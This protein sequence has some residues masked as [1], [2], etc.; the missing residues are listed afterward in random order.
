M[1]QESFREIY[2][3][4]LKQIAQFTNQLE[5]EVLA[6]FIVSIQQQIDPRED[7]AIFERLKGSLV[8]A[9]KKAAVGS[10]TH[11]TEEEFVGVMSSVNQRAP[12]D[13][14]EKFLRK[15]FNR[16]TRG[17]KPAVPVEEYFDFMQRTFQIR[18]TEEEQN[19]IKDKL[20]ES[21]DITKFFT[22]ARKGLLQNFN[23][24]R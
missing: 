19:L 5:I 14:Y 12:Q 13:H 22:I 6:E 24:G 17:K 2:R 4:L 9:Y 15:T 18:I 8:K 21:I 3:L 1:E 16:M 20:G 23:L 10:D 7:Q 11:I